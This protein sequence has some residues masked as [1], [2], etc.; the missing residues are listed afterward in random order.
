MRGTISTKL[1]LPLFIVNLLFA[2]FVYFLWLPSAIKVSVD[3]AADQV[4]RTLESVTE[5]IVPLLLQ[6]QLSNIHDTL[7]LIKE[8]NPSWIDLQ[9]FNARGQS[10]Y[11]LIVQE[12]PESDFLIRV[13]RKEIRV[14]DLR[15]G[16]IA[17]VHDM[18][19]LSHGFTLQIKYLVSFFVGFSSIL[20]V[21]MVFTLNFVIIA[22]VKA[23]T[24]AASELKNGNYTAP[25][26]TLRGDEIGTLIACFGDSRDALL[27]TR[28]D[29][30]A[31]RDEA[32]AANAAKSSFLANMSHELRT[33]MTGVLGITD[34]LLEDS[35]SKSERKLLHAIHQSGRRL[36]STLND[37]LDISKIEAGGL[38]L[39]IVEV[40]IQRNVSDM[41]DLFRPIADKK[42]IKL[43]FDAADDIPIF[44]ADSIKICQIITNLISNAVKF[45]ATGSVRV[46]VSVEREKWD[47]TLCV[48][49]TDSG[50]GISPDRQKRVFEKFSQEDMTVTR[51]Y[52]GTGLGLTICRELTHFLGGEI[53]VESVQGKGSAFWVKIPISFGSLLNQQ[54][55]APVELKTLTD[56]ELSE[57]SVLLVEDD[58]INLMFAQKVFERVGI[59]K[60]TLAENGQE[61]LDHVKS[62]KFDIVFMDCHMPILDGFQAT[63]AIRNLELVD[64]VAR[65]PIVALTANAMVGDREKCINSGMD[66]VLTK[67]FS[68]SKLVEMIAKWS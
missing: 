64:Q 29:L 62:Q 17:L 61:A 33:P 52:G 9:V 53:G 48:Q 58:P 67:P 54:R 60:F 41:V 21:L 63:Q 39:D 23:L 49:V 7:G 5:S 65:L 31:A 55:P 38:E 51:K 20:L 26:P 1:F 40:D 46:K 13:V 6:N 4:E 68:P 43:E 16:E 18:T 30:V 37:V 44:N 35:T 3:T 22:P 56:K 25:L 32:D 28:N 15:I 19:V 34:L 57:K 12:I 50:V 42:Q 45:T 24:R 36:L 14:G 27:D 47:G 59:R 10:V 8:S 2:V 66:D 11:P